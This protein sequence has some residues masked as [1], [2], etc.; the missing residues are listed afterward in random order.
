MKSQIIRGLLLSAAI[1][2][3][4]VGSAYAQDT[5]KANIPFGFQVGSHRLPAGE[6]TISNVAANIMA[7]RSADGHQG[8]LSVANRAESRKEVTVS[9]LV[10]L[11]YGEKYFLCSA[12]SAA[13]GTGRELPKPKMGR[14]I[15]ASAAPEQVV[16]LASSLGQ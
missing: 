1:V 12:W 11:R 9:K 7:V 10:F 13:S 15:I 16:I 4:T 2:A 8:A 3:V 14:E 5:L 6:Y